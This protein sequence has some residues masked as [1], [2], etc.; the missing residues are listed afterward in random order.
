M[1]NMT[2]CLSPLGQESFVVGGTKQG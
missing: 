1:K 2:S